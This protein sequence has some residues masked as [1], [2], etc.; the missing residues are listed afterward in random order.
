MIALVAGVAMMSSVGPGTAARLP[1]EPATAMS[2]ANAVHTS[3]AVRHRRPDRPQEAGKERDIAVAATWHLDPAVLRP[4]PTDSVATA[5][6]RQQLAAINDRLGEALARYD[7]ARAAAVLTEEAARRARADLAAALAA[8]K[9]ATERLRD[10]GALMVSLFTS[11]YTTSQLGPL[12]LLLTA[13][14]DEDLMSGLTML[15]EMGRRQTDAVEAA[16]ISRDRLREATLAV[17]AAEEAAQERL[18][19]ARSALAD[20]DA[21]RRA[22]VADVRAARRI[23]EQS[24]IADRDARDA[25]A[26]GYDGAIDFPLPAGTSYVDHHN[27]GQRSRHWA[28]VHTGDDLSAACGTPVLAVTDGTVMV[29][30][31]QSWS[32]PW[33]VVVSADDSTLTT[34]YAHLQA[35]DV[36]DGQHLHAGDRIGLVGQLGNATGCHLH[37]EVHPSGGSIYE[38]DTDPAAW[39]L[40]VG[41]YPDAA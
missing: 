1:A 31:D 24:E 13:D 40:A 37:L 28:S 17:A 6:A 32:G 35:L 41:A 30:T 10:D 36:V 21:A 20:A 38:D 14:S 7:E 29:R 25:V 33:L 11:S 9:V 23:V 18:T 5:A 26:G 12:S 2:A 34:W 27:F 15:E 3:A 39:L 8:Q 16:R 4:H 22:V 19:D